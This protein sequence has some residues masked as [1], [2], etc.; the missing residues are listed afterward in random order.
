MGWPGQGVTEAEVAGLFGCLNIFVYVHCCVYFAAIRRCILCRR[1]K[2][3][4]P[5]IPKN[6]RSSAAMTANGPIHKR[7]Q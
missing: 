5:C 2:A 6:I 4:S 3:L 1:L 7:T